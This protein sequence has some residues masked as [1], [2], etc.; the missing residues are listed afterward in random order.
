MDLGVRVMKGYSPFYQTL[1]G[2]K[3]TMKRETP[4]PQNTKK[5][6]SNTKERSNPWLE[7]S[8]SLN[9]LPGDTVSNRLSYYSLPIQLSIVLSIPRV[10]RVFSQPSL[11]PS[12]IVGKACWSHVVKM[13]KYCSS[14]TYSFSH[15]IKAPHTKDELFYCGDKVRHYCLHYWIQ[16]P[17]CHVCDRKVLQ[18][19]RLNLCILQPQS[20]GLQRFGEL[21]LKKNIYFDAKILLIF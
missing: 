5:Q 20:N 8:Y 19:C 1:I 6:Q 3:W 18:L 9:P 17:D 15:Y 7:L 10:Q 16:V 21:Y 14:S 2:G 11:Q 12:F 13:H 4:P